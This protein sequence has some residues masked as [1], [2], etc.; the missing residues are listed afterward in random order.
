MLW[1]AIK[2]ANQS[3]RRNALRSVL[4]LLG[5]VIGVG[6]VIAMVTIG[7]GTT[8]KVTSDLSKLGSNMLIAR[9]ERDTFGPGGGGEVRSFRERD[10]AA[11]REGLTQIRALAPASTKAVKIVYGAENTDSTV[12]GT[13]SEFFVA[14]DWTFASGR[15][16]SDGEIRSASSVCV[17][18]QTI[19]S[20]L[21]GQVDPVGQR[22]RLGNVSCEVIGLV[23]GKGQSAFGSDQDSIVFMPLRAF[24]RRIS[25]SQR[26]STI[27]LS[28]AS[29]EA[30]SAVQS[31]T[32]NILREQRRVGATEADDFSV[33][34]MSQIVST[35][36]STTILMTGLLS[37]VAAVSLLVGGIGIMNIMLVS[38]TERTREIGIRLAIGALEKQVLTQFLVEAIVL[39]VFGGMIGIALGLALAGWAAYAMSILFTA[40]PS[41]IALAFVFSGLI[42]VVFGYFPARRA[43]RLDP[44]EALRHE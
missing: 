29:A 34:D 3:V 31:A 20:V 14:Q 11:L 43:A 17:I 26:I 35:L 22:V 13:D 32:E 37:A 23:E 30:V 27:Y 16:F 38:V 8:E 39:S 36:S 12:T 5:I 1:E 33:R 15:P 24:Q 44:I 28:A 2:L 21:F 4:T 10:I 18:G 40:S 7:N 25:G 41:I 6:A 19:K 42:G 9:P